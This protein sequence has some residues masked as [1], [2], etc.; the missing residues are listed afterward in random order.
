MAL[1]IQHIF[2]NSHFS[3]TPSTFIAA[4]SA[5]LFSTQT[6]GLDLVASS[7]WSALASSITFAPGIGRRIVEKKK[8]PYRYAALAHR[9][10]RF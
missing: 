5:F 1:M 9:E 10:L 6:Y 3:V 8:N 4:G 7:M 2:A